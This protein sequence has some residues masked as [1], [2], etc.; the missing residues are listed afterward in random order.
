M[1]EEDADQTLKA[2]INWSRY[3]EAFA[4]DESADLFTLGD[5]D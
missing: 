3:G 1:S 5:P 2:V 4:Y